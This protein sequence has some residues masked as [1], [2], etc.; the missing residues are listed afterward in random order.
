MYPL[1]VSGNYILTW[2]EDLDLSE[3]NLITIHTSKILFRELCRKLVKMAITCT[4]CM[5]H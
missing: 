1:F 2:S 3:L 4:Q 5:P